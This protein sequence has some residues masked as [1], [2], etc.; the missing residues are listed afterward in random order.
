MDTRVYWVHGFKTDFNMC[1]MFFSYHSCSSPPISLLSYN[2]TNTEVRCSNRAVISVNTNVAR[3]ETHAFM[4][5]LQIYAFV[6]RHQIRA[7]V[8]EDVG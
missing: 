7:F 2:P 3:F 4:A 5:R 8:Q 6:A 1:I